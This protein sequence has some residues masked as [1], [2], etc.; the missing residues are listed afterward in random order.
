MSIGRGMRQHAGQNADA[1]AAPIL[2][3]DSQASSSPGARLLL[4]RSLPTA[5]CFA[6]PRTSHPPAGI[7]TPRWMSPLPPTLLRQ[8]RGGRRRRRRGS[9][10]GQEGIASPRDRDSRVTG[11]DKAQIKS[12]S[13]PCPV[14]EGPESTSPALFCLRRI[15]VPGI[16]MELWGRGGAG[17]RPSGPASPTMIV[18]GVKVPLGRRIAGGECVS[19]CPR[20]GRSP[21]YLVSKLHH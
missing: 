21:R 13:A 7:T 19:P 20:T 9:R 15:P 10:R 16:S 4:R 2:W 18:G 8:P 12:L 1:S 3:G 6:G 11:A 17:G 14:P 5:P